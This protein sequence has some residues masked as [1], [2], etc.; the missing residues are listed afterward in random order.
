MLAKT[1]HTIA[2]K[3]AMKPIFAYIRKNANNGKFI[4]IFFKELQTKEARDHLVSLGY[5][6]ELGFSGKCWYVRW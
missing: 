3:E 6:V 4:A 1:A 2:M 5:R